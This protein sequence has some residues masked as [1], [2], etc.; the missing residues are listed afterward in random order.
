MHIDWKSVKIMGPGAIVG[1]V[2]G[3]LLLPKSNVVF[4]QLFLAASIVLF[5]VKNFWFSGFTF[6]RKNNIVAAAGAGLGGGLLSGLI[7]TGGPVVTMY[8][9]VATPKKIGNAGHLYLHILY[10]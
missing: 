7:G 1:T 8:L 9:S 6:R 4:L 10:H 3:T 2:A 5:L